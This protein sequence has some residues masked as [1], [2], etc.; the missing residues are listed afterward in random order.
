MTDYSVYR[1][2]MIARQDGDCY[3]HEMDGC[4]S[5]WLESFDTLGEAIAYAEGVTLDEPT[6]FHTKLGLDSVSYEEIQVCASEY[7]EEDNDWLPAEC[8]HNVSGLP[9]R[10]KVAMRAYEICYWSWLDYESGWRPTL[11]ECLERSN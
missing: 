9:D 10:W 1:T 8:V 5:E 11:E 4:E 6:I 3:I 2:P 7:D